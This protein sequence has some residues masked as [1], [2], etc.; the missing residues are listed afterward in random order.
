M[1]RRRGNGAARQPARRSRAAFWAGLAVAVYAALAVT[2]VQ[3][4]RQAHDLRQI[5]QRL[6][7]VQTAKDD[8]LQEYRLLLLE[9]ATFAAHQNVE[10]VA[11]DE[12][13]MMFPEDVV[14]VER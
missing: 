12:L 8:Q 4:A 3:T 7:A 2:G 1:K 13:G 5:Y 14:K 10:R 11:S 6:S 9:R